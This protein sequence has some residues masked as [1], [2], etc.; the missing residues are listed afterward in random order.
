MRRREFIAGLASAAG[1]AASPLAAQLGATLVAAFRKGLSETGYV[2]GKNVAIEY[3]WAQ[4]ERERLADLAADL[5]RRRVTVIAAQGPAATLAAKSATATIPIVFIVAGD[6]VVAGLV[7]SLHRPGGNVTGISSMSQELMGKRLGLLQEL[8]PGAKRFAVLIDHNSPNAPFLTRDVQTAATALG[9][10]IEV[11]TVG[12]S[13][14]IDTAFAT[15]LQKRFEALLVTPDTLFTSRRPQILTSRHSVPT[16]FPLRADSMA[17]GLMSYGP[18][19]SDQDRQFGVY[20]GRI[21]MGE[22]AADL[23]VMQPTKFEFVIN[24]GTARALGTPPPPPL[25][26]TADEVIE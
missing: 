1:A 12:T 25:L 13:R 4:I 17:G 5:V 7:P 21:L 23:P 24:L 11:L 19:T 26:A 16:I 8:L 6:P 20:V 3:R 22:K 15:L 18:N 9:R 14:D 2:E 10:E